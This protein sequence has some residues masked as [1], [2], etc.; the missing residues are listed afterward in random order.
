MYFQ[1]FVI[2]V[3]HGWYAF[4]WKAFLL[5][6]NFAGPLTLP[7][8][9]DATDTEPVKNCLILTGMEQL[10]FFIDRSFILSA[11]CRRKLCSYQIDSC[12]QAMRSHKSS[13]CFSKLATELPSICVSHAKQNGFFCDEVWYGIFWCFGTW[14]ELIES[15]G[16]CLC[17]LTKW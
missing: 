1:C 16:S 13:C 10:N 7:I 17:N 6:P 2:Y 11:L 4:D 14:H 12:H 3:L 15:Y 9:Q 5:L 8:H